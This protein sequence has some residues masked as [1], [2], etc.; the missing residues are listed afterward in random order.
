MS[1]PDDGD[2]R[3]FRPDQ[4][5]VV[6]AG[7]DPAIHLFRKKMDAR[8]KSGDAHDVEMTAEGVKCRVIRGPIAGL[9]NP[10]A[11]GIR[12]EATRPEGFTLPGGS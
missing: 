9:K 1:V 11:D 3:E 12:F 10:L 7:L 5:A 8:I 6:I 2:Y 4:I